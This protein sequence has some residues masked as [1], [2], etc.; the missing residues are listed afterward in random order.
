[1]VR[2]GELFKPRHGIIRR[3]NKWTNLKD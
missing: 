1:M 3:I 2:N